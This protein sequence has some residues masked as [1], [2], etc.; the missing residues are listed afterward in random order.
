MTQ[1]ELAAIIERVPRTI[2]YIENDGQH[3]SLDRFYQMVTMFDIS[4]D[5]F[6]YPNMTVN[7]ACRKRIDVLLNKLDEDDL[8][9]VESLIQAV[10]DARKKEAE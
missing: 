10:K 4:V 9:L 7:D 6:F 2:M 1:E 5:Q 3:P 8:P